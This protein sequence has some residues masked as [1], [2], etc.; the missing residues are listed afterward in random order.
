MHVYLSSSVSSNT[1]AYGGA[2]NIHYDIVS[3]TN[4]SFSFIVATFLGGSIYTVYVVNMTM[5]G[6]NF[7]ENTVTSPSRV[8]SELRLYKVNLSAIVNLLIM[9]TFI[10]INNAKSRIPGALSTILTKLTIYGNST[11][12]YNSAI[13]GRAI[14]IT[15]S[16]IDV[17][18][19]LTVVNNKANGSGGGIYLYR[20]ELNCKASSIIKITSNTATEKGG[21]INAISSSIS[22]T[23]IREAHTARST[24]HFIANNTSKGGGLYLE[25]NAKL[26]IFKVGSTQKVIHTRSIFLKG[27][28]AEYGGAIYVADEANAGICQTSHNLLHS[29][30]TECFLQVLTLL[31]IELIQSSTNLTSLEFTNNSA[32]FLT[33]G[34]VLFGGLLDRCTL[35]PFAEV[36][37]YKFKEANYYNRV[38]YFT[39][40]TN[41]NA[42]DSSLQFISSN[43]V[44]VCFCR[45]GRPN[46]SYQPSK[47]T[48]KKGEVFSVPF[49]AV[50]Q[51]NHTVK[52]TSIHSTLTNNGQLD[53]GQHTQITGKDCSLYISLF[54]LHPLSSTIH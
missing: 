18:G 9:G 51:V 22:V 25:T 20:S 36:Y 16:V 19:K 3:V 26:Y 8:G 33:H 24:L 40:V 38:T 50:N 7:D 34:H 2:I 44:R 28:S 27:N 15:E 14:H 47:I 10:G 5:N 29:D 30:I 45:E 17:Y 21:G 12:M 37:R 11:L 1:A 39:S 48:V 13:N 41:I 43:P 31:L 42:S 32:Q 4:C 35:S 52:N 46:C 23:Y 6:C 54:H 53:V 49:V